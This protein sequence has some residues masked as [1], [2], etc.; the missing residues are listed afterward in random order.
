MWKTKLNHNII[1]NHAKEN[2]TTWYIQ[3]KIGTGKYKIVIKEIKEYSLKYRKTYHFYALE[4]SVYKIHP[5]W[6]TGLV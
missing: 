6:L 1:Y 3:N 4:D 5:N 2:K